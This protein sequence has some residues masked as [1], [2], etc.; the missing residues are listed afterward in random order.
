LLHDRLAEDSKYRVPPPDRPVV[1][2][3]RTGSQI[4][5]GIQMNSSAHSVGETKS[6]RHKRLYMGP[7]SESLSTEY[8]LRIHSTRLTGLDEEYKVSRRWGVSLLNFDAYEASAASAALR[9]QQ[10]A[11]TLALEYG[12]TSIG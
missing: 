4:I 6:G 9:R 2:N 8:I 1:S 5:F 3:V 10:S 11:N 7:V 12:S